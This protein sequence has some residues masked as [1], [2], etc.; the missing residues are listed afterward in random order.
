LFS[1][2]MASASSRL[3]TTRSKRCFS[4][5]ICGAPAPALLRLP[6]CFGSQQVNARVCARC[7]VFSVC[8]RAPLS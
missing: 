8:S 5:M 7:F 4:F 6:A 2:N 3:T 1:W